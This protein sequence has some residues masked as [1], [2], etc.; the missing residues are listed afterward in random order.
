MKA[1]E[2]DPKS[3]RIAWNTIIYFGFNKSPSPSIVPHLVFQGGG[4]LRLDNSSS[5]SFF[6]LHF[7]HEVFH[8]FGEVKDLRSSQLE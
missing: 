5:A 3:I 1:L 6:K 2:L 7:K 4:C 8:L